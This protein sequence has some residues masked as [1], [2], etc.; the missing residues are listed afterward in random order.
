LLSQ[1]RDPVA[2]K[3]NPV[4]FELVFKLVLQEHINRKERGKMGQS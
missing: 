2:S 4:L 3:Y 1:V